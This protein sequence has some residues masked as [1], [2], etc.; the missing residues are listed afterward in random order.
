MAGTSD[1]YS[2]AFSAEKKAYRVAN[3]E[4]RLLSTPATGIK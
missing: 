4:L 1:S 3:A 2:I